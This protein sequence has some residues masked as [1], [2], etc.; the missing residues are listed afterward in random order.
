ML[1]RLLA[2]TGIT[3]LL[4]GCAA[5]LSSD[6]YRRSQ[7][8]KAQSVEMG[9][10]D[11]IRPIKIEG[12]RDGIGTTAGA[13]LG[14]IAGSKAGGGDRANAAGA[15]VGAIVGGIAG[16]AIEEQ[17]TAREGIEVTVKLDSGRMIA[18]VQEALERFRPGDR[19]RILSDGRT[20]RVTF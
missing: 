13:V 10:V 18:V 14:G 9:I 16:H 1:H 6:T 17:T 3:L 11:S 15:V 2:L 12:R 8:M 20:T 4:A 7:V 19:V 5:S